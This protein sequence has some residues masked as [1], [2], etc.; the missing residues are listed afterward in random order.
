MSRAIESPEEVESGIRFHYDLP[1]EFFS[2]FLDID[3]ELLTAVQV[4][5]ALLSLGS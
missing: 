1:P 2:L 5:S 4:G 3:G